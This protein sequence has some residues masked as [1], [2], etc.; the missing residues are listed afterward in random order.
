MENGLGAVEGVE[1]TLE[2]TVPPEIPGSPIRWMPD[3]SLFNTFL[4]RYRLRDA[5]SLW[6]FA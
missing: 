4:V 2:L 1:A 6:S 3:I 5:W